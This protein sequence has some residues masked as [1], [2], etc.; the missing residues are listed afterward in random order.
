MLVSVLYSSTFYQSKKTVSGISLASELYTI[1][2]IWACSEAYSKV[3]HRCFISLNILEVLEGKK[4]VLSILQ[5][6]EYISTHEIVTDYK[7]SYY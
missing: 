7:I 5:K 2:D 6:S 1:F 4:Y 3:Q